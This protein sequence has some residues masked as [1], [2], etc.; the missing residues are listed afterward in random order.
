M[1]RIRVKVPGRAYPLAA[2]AGA[3]LG[4]GWDRMHVV[5]GTLSYAG[6]AHAQPWWVPVEFALA[7]VVGLAGIARWG[8]PLPDA[9]SPRRALGELVVFSAIYGLTALLWERSALLAVIL[10]VLLA[11]RLPALQRA[12]AANPGPAIALVAGGPLA[13]GLV[14]ASG[15]FS[16][17]E[18]DFAGVPIWLPLVY[19]HAVPFFV[20]GMEALLWVTRRPAE[21]AREPGQRP[22]P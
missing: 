16:Y 11:V 17:T 10:V 21:P 13:E 12:G 6:T 1:Q 19:M 4:T 2:I 14:S 18:T 15:L 5:A 3:V 20:R 8:D 7:F 9:A 22:A